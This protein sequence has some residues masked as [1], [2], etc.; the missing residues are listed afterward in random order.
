MP[1]E[2]NNQ[3]LPNTISMSGSNVL[4]S[5]KFASSEQGKEP[6]RLVM[7]ADPSAESR[8]VLSTLL[9]RHG[10]NTVEASDIAQ[11]VELLDQH[12]PDLL[13][14]DMDNLVDLDSSQIEQLRAKSSLR[15]TPI[16]V[17]GTNRPRF[18]PRE[19]TEFVRKP[20][21]YGLLLLKIQGTL[22]E[23]LAA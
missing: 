1:A 3:S 20:Y 4:T 11:A 19:G 12:A 9:A 10:A 13:V 7:I 15:N 14:I 5:A 16:V 17:L 6:I 18:L 8:E 22:D 2:S 23:R 21:H